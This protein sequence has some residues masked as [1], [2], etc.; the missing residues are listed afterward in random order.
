MSDEAPDRAINPYQPPSAIDDEVDPLISTFNTVKLDLDD[1]T[2]IPFLGAADP[3][4]L[5]QFLK[6]HDAIS[7][8]P[9]T[10]AFLFAALFQVWAAI[11]SGAL[12]VIVS[13][14]ILIF[15]LTVI[16]STRWYRASLFRAAHPGWDSPAE[17][18]LTTEGIH[19]RRQ[20]ETAFYRWSWFS[21]VVIAADMVGFVPADDSELPVFVNS[22]MLPPTVPWDRLILFARSAKVVCE[23]DTGNL[24]IHWANRQ[25]MREQGRERS[26][27]PPAEAL[28][29]QGAVTGVDVKALIGRKLRP[30]RPLRAHAIRSLL[31]LAVVICSLGVL[32][33]MARVRS[34]QM[35]VM[36]ISVG[37]LALLFLRIVWRREITSSDNVL[38]YLLGHADEEG[39]T[40]DFFVAVTTVPWS[41]MLVLDRSPDRVLI[42]QK[43]SRKLMILRADMFDSESQ[44]QQFLDLT[45]QSV[46]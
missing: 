37:M 20:T 34:V 7:G 35:L 15:A 19:I 12:A 26:V 5:K 29:F 28:R 31:L 25:V 24:N 4:D 44:W 40:V 41:N 43:S 23:N 42:R 21:G 18:E 3:R 16:T 2:Q 46:S 33:M 14:I 32:A 11:V 38:Y 10:L 27:R 13:G 22:K 39:I 30:G 17:G 9:L 1:K 36:L 8:L 6:R 45:S